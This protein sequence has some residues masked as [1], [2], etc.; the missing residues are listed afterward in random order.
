MP[1]T[2]F[3]LYPKTAAILFMVQRGLESVLVRVMELP[4]LATLL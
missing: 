4:R 3:P 2:A 1:T